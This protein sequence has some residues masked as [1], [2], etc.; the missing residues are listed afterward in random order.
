[1]TSYLQGNPTSSYAAL[2]TQRTNL[3]GAIGYVWDGVINFNVS[4]LSASY[5][6]PQALS[7]VVSIGFAGPTGPQGPSGSAGTP[8]VTG[9]AGSYNLVTTNTYGQVTSGSTVNYGLSGS[10]VQI[11]SASALPTDRALLDML[12]GSDAS[13]NA[14]IMMSSPY[15]GP[16]AGVGPICYFNW[17]YVPSDFDPS[18][19]VYIKLSNINR[20]TAAT[21]TAI[22]GISCSVGTPA[23]DHSGWLT[24]PQTLTGNLTND[25]QWTRIGPF[26][27]T[28][29]ANQEIA[30]AYSIPAGSTVAL[31]SYQQI[32]KSCAASTDTVNLPGLTHGITPALASKVEYFTQKTRFVVISDSIHRAI[33]IELAASLSGTFMRFAAPVGQGLN[34]LGRGWSVSME[35]VGSTSM[36]Q[37]ANDELWYLKDS[38]QMRGAIVLI[39]LGTN[40]LLL[41]GSSLNFYTSN[42]TATP[43]LSGYFKSIV[44]TCRAAGAA[45]I[46]GSTMIPCSGSNAFLYKWNT[47]MRTKPYGIDYVF[48]AW[49]LVKDPANPDAINPLY[50]E[51]LGV[52]LNEL[53]LRV[54][55]Q[56]FPQF[57]GF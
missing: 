34:G 56:N 24:T 6:V 42:T 57:S 20:Y 4:P 26:T 23:T 19:S 46:I 10:F 16:Q 32:G 8:G 52:H 51:S 48:D 40:D 44:Q 45:K 21:G 43:T 22:T 53:G 7:G 54:L 41:S 28:P 47:W 38:I 35:G 3:S 49:S 15:A 27:A 37:W 5:G 33:S 36:A 9:S 29:N 1:M 14:S 18:G 31:E 13:P 55:C 2:E 17:L 11:V 25:G 12:R 30:Y 50:R 39:A